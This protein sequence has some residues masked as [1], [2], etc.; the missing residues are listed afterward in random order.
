M[1]LT[2]SEIILLYVDVSVRMFWFLFCQRL[3]LVIFLSNSS[4]KKAL[5]GFFLH[6]QCLLIGLYID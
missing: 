4:R 3:Y 1:H 5:G 2:L 6:L